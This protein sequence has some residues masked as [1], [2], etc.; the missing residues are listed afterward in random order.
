MARPLRPSASAAGVNTRPLT[1]IP[2]GGIVRQAMGFTNSLCVA[3]FA[4]LFG[5]AMRRGATGLACG[6]KVDRKKAIWLEFG[7]ESYHFARNIACTSSSSIL[8]DTSIRRRR[9][10]NARTSMDMHASRVAGRSTIRA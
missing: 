9:G 5:L 10:Q 4:T 1:R 8:T 2:G 6:M 3:I 7:G